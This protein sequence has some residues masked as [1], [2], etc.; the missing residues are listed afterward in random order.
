MMTHSRPSFRPPYAHF[1]MIYVDHDGKV[2][3]E[4]SASIQEQNT[5]IFTPEVR[6]SFLEVLGERI[7]YQPPRRMSF[8]LQN[9]LAHT[10]PEL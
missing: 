5:T 2:K 6:Q 10:N 1:S 7:G 4:E 9:V 3:V 8:H